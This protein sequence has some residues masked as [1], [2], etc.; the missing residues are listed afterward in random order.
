MDDAKQLD[1]ARECVW[2]NTEAVFADRMLTGIYNK[3]EKNWNSF[4]ST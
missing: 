2:E 1:S 3:F 4:F